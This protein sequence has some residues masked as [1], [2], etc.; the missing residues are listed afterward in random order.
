MAR[1]ITNL[2]LGQKVKYFDKSYIVTGLYP[3]IAYLT[4]DKNINEVI[5]VNVGDLVVAGIEPSMISYIPK[6]LK[7]K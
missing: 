2:K 1:R 3:C 6:Y 7:N 5:C 4:D